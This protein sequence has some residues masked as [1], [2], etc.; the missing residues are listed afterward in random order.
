MAS[1]QQSDAGRLRPHPSEQSLKSPAPGSVRYELRVLQ[2]PIRARACGFGTKDRRRV[3][4]PPVVEL[5]KY[6][7]RNIRD[8]SAQEEPYL[9]CHA[10]LCS[11]DGTEDR[12][13]INNIYADESAGELGASQHALVGCAVATA[14]PLKDVH[15][16]KKL[17]F[18]FPDLSV[19]PP[20]HLRL[21]FRLVDLRPVFE[22]GTGAGTTDGEEQNVL[23]SGGLRTSSGP[24]AFRPVASTSRVTT[25]L[26]SQEHINMAEEAA[27]SSAIPIQAMT[28]SDVFTCYRAKQFPGMLEST[29]LSKC[30]VAQG[31][32]DIP[33]RDKGVDPS[34]MLDRY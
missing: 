30:L 4:P 18:I 17:M 28:L 16:V 15:G 25:A 33:I 7:E 21:K 1:L 34:R 29:D 12:G 26:T 9:V 11:A 19:R 13:L 6:D 8:S 10:S 20:G 5:I 32:Q 24:S 14:Q 31:V 2:Q 3:D 27:L 23:T 22:R